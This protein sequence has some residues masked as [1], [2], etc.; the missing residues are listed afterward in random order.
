MSYSTEYVI[1]EDATGEARYFGSF[2][3]C[4]ILGTPC[5]INVSS[6]PDAS[7]VAVDI[8]GYPAFRR[9][10]MAIHISGLDTFGKKA[11]SGHIRSLGMYSVAWTGRAP[12][13]P[14]LP[15]GLGCRA[16]E[17]AVIVS[18]GFQDWGHHAMFSRCDSF[19]TLEGVFEW[20]GASSVRPD[21]VFEPADIMNTLNSKRVDTWLYE[22]QHLSAIRRLLEGCVDVSNNGILSDDGKI[23]VAAIQRSGRWGYQWRRTVSQ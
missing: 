2:P 16:P 1:P 19:L 3:G 4:R 14:G 12:G 7:P 23:G 13:L 17:P 21:W 9:N 5:T 20:A 18:N 6:L 11:N 10:G 15:S 22:K 8:L